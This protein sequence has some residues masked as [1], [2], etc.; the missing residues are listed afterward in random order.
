MPLL[1]QS[2]NAHSNLDSSQLLG[3]DGQTSQLSVR[4]STAATTVRPRLGG[5]ELAQNTFDAR[6]TNT[7]LPR[8]MRLEAHQAEGSVKK[9]TIPISP[10]F[11]S[12]ERANRRRIDT[13]SSV[14]IQHQRPIRRITLDAKPVTPTLY[15]LERAR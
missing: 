12:K 6:S 3:K 13:E 8:A 4:V 11:A 14:M 1:A 7:G 10:K 15:T 5:L 9:R 2:Y